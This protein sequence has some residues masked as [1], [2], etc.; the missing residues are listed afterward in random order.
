MQ[1]QKGLENTIPSSPKST[2]AKSLGRCAL[3]C[4]DSQI[5]LSFS[6][7]KSR[8]EWVCSPAWT[9]EVR[10]KAPEPQGAQSTV[11]TRGAR[12]VPLSCSF[13][14]PKAQPAP[15]MSATLST[16]YSEASTLPQVWAY[17]RS[18]LEQ[19]TAASEQ[20]RQELHCLGRQ[21]TREALSLLCTDWWCTPSAPSDTGNTFVG[22]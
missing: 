2:E 15:G 19:G 6:G 17:K 4:L 16:I 7:S 21:S 22:T 14:R 10:G 8:G 18:A 3:P 12:A 9:E 20:A 5:I 11:I 13:Q 1:L